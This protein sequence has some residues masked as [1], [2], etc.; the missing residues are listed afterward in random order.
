MPA[1]KLPQG[2]R[3]ALQARLGELEISH[4]EAA[5]R[6]SL[7]NTEVS[8]VV[9][10][11]RAPTVRVIVRLAIGLDQDPDEWLRLAGIP[12]RVDPSISRED[13]LTARYA[14]TGPAP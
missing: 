6:S 9:S 5:R 2:F 13:L 1:S 7:A 3:S 10:G 14:P 8:R 4:R 11:Q 12:L